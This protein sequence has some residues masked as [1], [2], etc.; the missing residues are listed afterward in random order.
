MY[1]NYFIDSLFL[2]FCHINLNLFEFPKFNK[3][4]F[5]FY[6]HFFVTKH[7]YVKITVIHHLLADKV[8][9]FGREI[10][11]YKKWYKEIVSNI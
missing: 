11:I 8:V 1:L 9:L 2:H 10:H 4:L 5:F 3:I 7:T 6:S